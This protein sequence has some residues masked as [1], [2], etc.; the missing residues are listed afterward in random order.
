MYSFG[1]KY[2]PRKNAQTH[3]KITIRTKKCLKHLSNYIFFRVFAT[4][5]YEKNQICVE[6]RQEICQSGICR[7]LSAEDRYSVIATDCQTVQ[8]GGKK[9]QSI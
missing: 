4:Y 8:Y 3:R 5:E 9:K 2:T 7:N 6:Y 1:K